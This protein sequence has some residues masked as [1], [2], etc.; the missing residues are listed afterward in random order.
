MR[1]EP[2]GAFFPVYPVYQPHPI[3][4]RRKVEK[5]AKNGLFQQMLMEAFERE[6]A[7]ARRPVPKPVELSPEEILAERLKQLNIQEN[8]IKYMLM[9]GI[10]TYNPIV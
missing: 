2:I 5:P 1:I 8:Y 10:I 4:K 9:A 3:R 6:E 7:A